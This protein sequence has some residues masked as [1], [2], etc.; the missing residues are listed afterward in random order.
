MTE[1]SALLSCTVLGLQ[2]GVDVDHV[3]AISDVTSIQTTPRD[4]VRSGL[5]Y[6]A[7]HA[8]TVGLIGV[9]F[10]TLRRS[11]PAGFSIW[12]Q[13]IVGLTLIALGAYVLRAAVIGT[14]PVGRGAAIR[15]LIGKFRP[16]AKEAHIPAD[17]TY[18]PKSS[19]GLGVLHGWARKHQLSSLCC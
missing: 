6:A 2:H 3:A 8:V 7:G 12:M 10:I 18:G 16:S 13:R 9:A 4:A 14:G 19:V 1:I 17:S 15:A 5:L 11:V